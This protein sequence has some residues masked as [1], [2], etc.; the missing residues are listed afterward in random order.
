MSYIPS[1]VETEADAPKMTHSVILRR[2]NDTESL[3]SIAKRFAARKSLI[4]EAN[5]METEEIKPG[6]IILVPKN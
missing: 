1:L 2:A 6:S 4:M 5:G 3:W